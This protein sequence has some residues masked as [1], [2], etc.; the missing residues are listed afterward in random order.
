MVRLVSG[1][2]RRGNRHRRDHL[3]VPGRIFVEVDDVADIQYSSGSTSSPK[4]VLITQKAIVAN[5][6]GILRDG[7]SV[8]AGSFCP[9]FDGEE[10][11][12]PRYAALVDAGCPSGYAADDDDEGHESTGR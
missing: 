10:L 2:A 12:Q 1:C 7:L 9:H 4:G 11:R 6:R 3:S 8:R 5:T